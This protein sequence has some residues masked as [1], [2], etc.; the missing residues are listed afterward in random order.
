MIGW[1]ITPKVMRS[2]FAELTRTLE[3]I[4]AA[5][6]GAVELP[7][8][9]TPSVP[10]SVL[11]RTAEGL[12]LALSA[13]TA[14]N[15]RGISPGH[16]LGIARDLGCSLLVVD[17]LDAC[18]HRRWQDAALETGVTLVLAAADLDGCSGSRGVQ[19]KVLVELGAPNDAAG[20]GSAL[21]RAAGERLGCVRLV[22]PC[23]EAGGASSSREREW[24]AALAGCA[25]AGPV[26][27]SG[28]SA[29]HASSGALTAAR[30][31]LRWT[32]K[33]EWELS[34]GGA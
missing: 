26:I 3:D 13:R 27:C 6:I 24:A 4:A 15:L 32:E 10:V 7:T 9:A 14:G 20:S 29:F 28:D 34:F 21:L 25:Y 33:V 11:R 12:G 31:L 8:D 2:P 5:G 18:A 30:R 23:D 1:A 19:T 22:P 16:A 17:A